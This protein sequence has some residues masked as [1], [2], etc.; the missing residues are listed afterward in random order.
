MALMDSFNNGIARGEFIFFNVF[1]M[2]SLG[3][4]P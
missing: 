1:L 4:S 2:T 3:L